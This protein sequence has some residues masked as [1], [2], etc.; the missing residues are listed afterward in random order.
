MSRILAAVAAACFCV[1][2]A[3]ASAMA[4]DRP[5]TGPAPTVHPGTKLSFPPSLGGATLVHGDMFGADAAYAY[6]L[7]NRLQIVVQIKD[8]GRRMPTGSDNPQITSLFSA[9]LSLAE[10]QAKANGLTRFERPAVSS[11]CTYGTTTF[12][13]IVFNAA[14]GSARAYSKMLMTGYNGFVLVIHADWALANQTTQADA[15]AALQAFVPALLR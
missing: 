4:Q 15:D 5:P 8:L 12:R 7:P 2:A 14:G 6:V 10:Q 13:C 1:S 11:S 9:E 3:M